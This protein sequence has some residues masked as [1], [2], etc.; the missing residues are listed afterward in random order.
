MDDAFFRMPLTFNT[1]SMVVH[2]IADVI[3]TM[4][5]GFMDWHDHALSG[6]NDG[7][8]VVEGSEA[9]QPVSKDNN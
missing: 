3:E 6:S 8:L 4:I 7:H 9:G 5:P 1:V 2:R